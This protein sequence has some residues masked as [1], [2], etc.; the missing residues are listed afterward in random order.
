MKRLL[1]R[2]GVEVSALGMG[3]WAIG[4]PH[5]RQGSP[6]GWGQVNDDESIR[7]LKRAFEL[8]VNFYDTADVY[9]CGHSEDLIATA[10]SDKRDQIVIATKAGY[11]YDEATREAPGTNG[12]PDYIRWCCDQS[13]RRLKTDYIDLYQFHL[14]GYDLA[15][16]PEVLAVFE[17][18]VTQGKVRYI[19]WSTDDPPRVELFAQSPHCVAIQQGFNLFGGNQE[20]LALCEKYNLASILR[21]PLAMG[22]LTGKF[23]PDTKLPEDD[24]RHGWNFKEGG[25][26]DA[27]KKVESI[28]DVLTSG[29]RTVAQGALA[30]LWARSPVMIPI[31][32]FKTVQQAEENIGAMQ[33]GPLTVEQ[34]RQIDDI[35][36][37]PHTV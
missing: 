30:W 21:G 34:M 8:G 19:G 26:A 32:G 10:L 31:P 13:L 17:E 2:S 11:T 33:F 7:A 18:L 3:C 5:A 12:D 37:R 24:I 23:T 6:V 36:G 22:M 20:T 25:Q 1:G 9:G 15:K 14:G 35:L 29:G 4:G 16:A 27:M 28:R